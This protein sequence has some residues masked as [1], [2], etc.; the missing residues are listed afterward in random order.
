MKPIEIRACVGGFTVHVDGATARAYGAKKRKKP[1]DG[2][3]CAHPDGSLQIVPGL[4]PAKVFDR[5]GA[6][7]IA[8]QI[9][10]YM[11]G[12]GD[13]VFAYTDAP[14]GFFES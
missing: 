3:V 12:F 7:S 11:L 14:A 5:D 10:R 6:A 4:N 9:G 8:H 2:N 13:L 1:V